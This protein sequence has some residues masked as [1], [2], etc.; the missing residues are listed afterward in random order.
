MTARSFV[1]RR[2]LGLR[3]ATRVG[4]FYGLMFTGIGVMQPFWPAW[5]ETRGLG[6]VEIGL[7][8]AA[9]QWSKVLVNPVVASHVDRTG[10]RRATMVGLALVS[11]LCFALLQPLMG[12]WPILLMAVPATACMAGLM[13]L[14]ESVAMG[15]VRAT[16]ADYGRMRLW[17]SI[18][19]MVAAVAA[20]ALLDVLPVTVVVPTAILSALSL[21][22]LSAAA[23]PPDEM[24]VGAPRGAR[25]PVFG[26][27][28]VLRL[29]RDRRFLLFLG[30]V[31]LSQGSHAPYY[32]FSTLHW[33]AAGL[34]DTTIGVLWAFGVVVEVALFAFGNRMVARLGPL[35]L[36]LA[37]AAGGLVRWS[38]LAVTVHPVALF[39][40][41]GLHAL[42][43]AAGHLGAMHFIARA[44]PHSHA[45][46]AQGLYSALAMGA[47]LGL[48]MILSGWLYARVGGLAFF[49]G[50]GLCAG[51][52]VFG[53]LLART[54]D[55]GALWGEDPPTEVVE[56]APRVS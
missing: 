25:R 50:T 7:V 33:R 55:G 56:P 34:S 38:V 26:G 48:S 6:A 36:L 11:L 30:C 16:G 29:L 9:A 37:A 40:V 17:G 12:F 22:V 47:V 51:A 27:D 41:Q 18:T 32:G 23:L 13:P 5:L 15:V 14:A 21:T 44:V 20:G 1:S 3:A 35:G 2:V 28:G 53:L 42:T 39:A 24:R 45:V 4:L 19:F 8:M 49:L 10:A 31:G 46:R 54:W 43:Y 52:S